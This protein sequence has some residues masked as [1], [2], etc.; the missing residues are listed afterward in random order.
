MAYSTNNS[1]QIETEHNAQHF[2]WHLFYIHFLDIFS[3]R[4]VLICCL[5]EM[6]ARHSPNFIFVNDSYCPFSY[7]RHGLVPSAALL[8]PTARGQL[9]SRALNLQSPSRALQ[10]RLKPRRLDLSWTN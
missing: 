6:P 9:V 1:S 5:I 7:S 10:S 3:E 2:A 4:E 8:L